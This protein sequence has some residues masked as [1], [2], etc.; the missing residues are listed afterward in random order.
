M[1]SHG[2]YVAEENSPSLIKA[3]DSNTVGS[4]DLMGEDPLAMKVIGDFTLSAS[5]RIYQEQRIFVRAMFNSRAYYDPEFRFPDGT[6]RVF[7]NAT[8]PKLQTAVALLMPI[9][10][11]PGN[12]P[13]TVDPDSESIDPKEAFKL[14]T[15]GVPPDMVRDQMYQ[16]AGKKSDR[17]MAKIT[18]G[19]DFTR[20]GDKTVRFLWD[21]ALF[22]TGIMMGPLAVRNPETVSTAE[23]DESPWDTVRATQ[24]A[25]AVTPLVSEAT[26][27][28]QEPQETTAPKMGV[29]KKKI[30][31]NDLLYKLGLLDKYM[32]NLDVIS[33]LDFYND[34]A[35]FTIES[36][37]F[38]IWRMTLSKP[39]MIE[40]T[41]DGGFKKDVVKEV[42]EDNPT[43]CWKPAYWETAIN[44]LNNQPAMTVP[45][46]RYTC[47]NWW[48]Y[49]TGKDLYDAGV[50]DIPKSRFNE[51]V[52]AN[53]WVV[54]GK[55]VKVAV[56][57]LHNERL[58]FFVT[59]YSIA[60]NSI[61]GVGPCE[62]MF[63]SQDALNALER[64]LIDNLAVS[65]AP[66][67]IVDVDRLAD[68]STVLEIKPKKIWAVRGVAGQTNNP[69][70]FY[71][72]DCVID[73]ILKAMEHESQL[74]QEQTGLPNFLQGFQ[75]DGVHNRTSTGA[76]L[77]FNNS[78]TTL[79]SVCYNIENTLIVP[80]VQKLIRFFQMYSE[81][82]MVKGSFRVSAHGT[83]G[84]MARES[85][86]G[87]MNDLFQNLGNLPGQADRLKWDNIF[88]TYFRCFN[89]ADKDLVYSDSEYAKIQQQ[90]QEEQQKNAAYQAGI[91]ASVQSVP[92]QRAE[93]PVKDA[94]IEQ[95]KLSPENSSLRLA[96]QEMINKAY[97]IESPDVKEAVEQAKT[98]EHLGNL[99]MAHDLGAQI[100]ERNTRRSNYQ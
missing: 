72:P 93:M 2:G 49:L 13:F 60:P 64:A 29:V 52:V 57:E 83:R 17:L 82:P 84:L 96:F 3:S 76:T 77:Q 1:E 36:S 44:A 28:T 53:I 62:S 37:R 11:P 54:G 71:V 66:Q 95:A 5:S 56:S 41:N 26:S 21:L 10:C 12:P 38:G 4:A 18:K 63:D 9:I 20:F 47:Y 99:N 89:L 46:G 98:M 100:A 61:W 65:H 75:G 51:R 92:K 42:L 97:N 50:K 79:K 7:V 70:E 81:D 69:V 45:S 80:M 31:P 27:Y 85:L 24:G 14:L 22:G 59:P 25:A 39:Q 48:G 16:A 78:V 68:P 33:P 43:G 86:V 58:P 34:P 32:F 87:M 35:A 73:V 91:D 88:N 19:L 8:R 15:Q 94:L 74:A 67:L 23:S 90:K 40:M 6:S 30:D 55:T